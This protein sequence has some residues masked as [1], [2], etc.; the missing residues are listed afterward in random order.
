MYADFRSLLS[1]SDV[2]NGY[3]LAVEQQDAALLDF[4]ARKFTT[5]TARRLGVTTESV[6]WAVLISEY[7]VSQKKHPYQVFFTF[8]DEY[9]A[10]S[11][12]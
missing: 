4:D 5:W 9:R 8:L 12:G 10:A 11:A 3:V 1:L 7:A 2:V 6:G